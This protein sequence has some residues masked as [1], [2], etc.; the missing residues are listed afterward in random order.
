MAKKW[1]LVILSLLALGSA[2]TATQISGKA[3][4]WYSLE[5]LSKVIVDIN[6][7]PIQTQV[8]D[9]TGYRFEVPAGS[10]YEIRGRLF[11][12]N[13]L[14][15][16]D[17]ETVFVP[18]DGNF[19]VDLILFPVLDSNEFLFDEDVNLGLE[20]ENPPAAESFSGSL[21]LA[22]VILALIIIWIVY[23]WHKKNS[24]SFSNP[25]PKH[26]QQSSTDL[27]PQT[28]LDRSEIVSL[29]RRTDG[30]LTQKEIRD[31]I[32]WSEAKVS[33]VLTELESLGKIKKFKKGRGNIVVLNE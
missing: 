26:S 6:S 11:E 21:L 9:E 30:R 14:K 25:I 5:P 28:E 7:Q 20:T 15:Y 23:H 31:K 4:E 18:Q 10:T 12:N 29:L 13:Q 22:L 19:V 17:T 27:T 32:D 24:E 3:F 2:V 33:L 16:A 8:T 1:L